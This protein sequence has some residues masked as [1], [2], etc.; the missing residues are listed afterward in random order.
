MLVEAINIIN[1]LYN[2]PERKSLKLSENVKDDIQIAHDCLERYAVNWGDLLSFSK[3]RVIANLHTEW[4]E[5]QELFNSDDYLA[6]DV[7]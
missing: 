2:D 3:T 1:V 7:Q 4:C 6:G 5:Q